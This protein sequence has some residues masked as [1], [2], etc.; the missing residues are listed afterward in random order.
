MTLGK[1]NS[2]GK[3]KYKHDASG[4]SET[5][6]VVLALSISKSEDRSC[7]SIVAL[8][9]EA[10]QGGAISQIWLDERQ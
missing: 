3:A 8:A 2:D 5:R 1:M 10:W 7:A 4:H 6:G 9:G